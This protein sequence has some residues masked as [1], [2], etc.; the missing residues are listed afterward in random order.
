MRLKQVVVNLLDNAI[1]YTPTGGSLELNVRCDG[2]EA[3]LEVADTGIGINPAQASR[4]FDR[5]FRTEEVRSGRI[6]GTGLGL[7]IVQSIAEAHGGSIRMTSR[8]KQ[9][10][11][12]IVRLARCE[13][14]KIRN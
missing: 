8:E 7:A 12:F 1:K 13:A 11:S 2:D 6:E 14:D 9:G 4:V 5:F 3:V 10:T